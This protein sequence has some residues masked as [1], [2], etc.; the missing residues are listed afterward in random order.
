MFRLFLQRH[1]QDE[2]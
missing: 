2:P 1:L